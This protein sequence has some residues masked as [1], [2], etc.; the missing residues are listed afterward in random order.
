M[1]S[2]I[3]YKGFTLK[4][5]DILF[6]I[7]KTEKHISEFIKNNKHIDQFKSTY[8]DW[9][10]KD[11]LAHVYE[12]L[13]Y[14]KLKLESIKNK[15]SFDLNVNADEFNNSMFFKDK[16]LPLNQII[17]DLN[18]AFL[19]YKK[20]IDLY[21]DEE[22][23]SRDFPT[24]FSFE[25]WRYMLLDAVIHPCRHLMYHY[26]KSKASDDFL[27]LIKITKNIFSLYTDNSL[28]IYDFR[29]FSLYTKKLFDE[30]NINEKKENNTLF[31]KIIELNK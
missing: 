22:L 5:K 15:T 20:I 19:E 16:D 1:I 6:E 17:N 23:L 9:N 21:S 25:L 3:C 2:R 29:D 14:S 31:F 26:L 4:K 27:K 12:W 11:V 24:G 18:T 28:S 7:V 10:Y 13:K 8:D 30:I